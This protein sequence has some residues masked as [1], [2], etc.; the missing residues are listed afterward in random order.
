[1]PS[2][3]MGTRSCLGGGAD[4]H[5]GPHGGVGVLVDEDERAGGSFALVLVKQQGLGKAQ[6]AADQRPERFQI[7]DKVDA[8]IVILCL[9]KLC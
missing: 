8:L 4:Q 1:M 5:S 7:G 3:F 2:G 6:P 9:T